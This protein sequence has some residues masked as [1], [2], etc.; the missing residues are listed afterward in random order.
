MNAKQ[1]IIFGAIG[2]ITPYLVTLLSIDFK[3]ICISYETLDWVGLIVRCFVL[4]FL[5]SLVAYLHKT[6]TEPFKV[7]QLGLAAPAL[8]ATFINGSAGNYEGPPFLVD[9][10]SSSIASVSIVPKAFAEDIKFVNSNMLREAKVSETS[11]F[12][13]GFLGT[14]LQTSEKE[15]YFVIVGSHERYEQAEQ[16]VEKLR[17]KNYRAKIY[18]PYM[19]S[20]HYAVVIASNVT[21]KEAKKLK[22]RAISDGLPKDSYIWTY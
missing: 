20:K 1:R 5:G 12:F 18:K 4:I 2:G 16:Q 6:E 11:R 8:L 15:T 7:F 10:N 14:K 9:A 17:H 21:Q 22:K 19:F 13:R 3:A